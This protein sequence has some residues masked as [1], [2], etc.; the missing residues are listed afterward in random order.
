MTN[1]YEYRPKEKALHA[2]LI[3]P[4]YVVCIC[5]FVL[6][7]FDDISYEMIR[8]FRVKKGRIAEEVNLH[9]LKHNMNLDLSVEGD[10]WEGDVLGKNPCGW[11]SLY[12]EDNYLIYH[13]CMIL[14]NRMCY[15]E[16]YYPT[17]N[18]L[19]RYAGGWIQNKHMGYGRLYD[20]HGEI[21]AEGNW[22]NDSLKEV[23]SVVVTSKLLLNTTLDS[24]VVNLVIAD[25]TCN[26]VRMKALNLSYLE[27][28]RTLTIGEK[29][30]ANVTVFSLSNLQ[31]LN[32]ITIGSKSFNWKCTGEE[33]NR[34]I[35]SI[36]SCHS[37]HT[38]IIGAKSFC[39]YQI[40][41]IE[42]LPSLTLL[43]IG[44]DGS[45]KN[46]FDECPVFTLSALPSLKDVI[47]GEGCFRLVHDVSFIGN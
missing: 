14:S 19:L 30:F 47:I 44:S 31:Y 2:L 43:S 7:I 40:F 46:C 9:S 23:S 13:G 6:V 17:S 22:I 3:V 12:N 28:L 15:G 8:L 29:C 32:S 24:L 18:P 41:V 26:F 36:T 39:D 45:G 27:S 37:L 25:N 5:S 33:R 34:C 1:Y 16:D 10:H 35:F 4:G 21:L 42:D 38:I 11:G 20:L